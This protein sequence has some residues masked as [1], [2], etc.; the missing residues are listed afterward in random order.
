MNTYASKTVYMAS[1]NFLWIVSSF[2]SRN[3]LLL[4][5][6][7]FHLPLTTQSR[8]WSGSMMV[9]LDLVGYLHFRLDPLMMTLWIC[10]ALKSFLSTSMQ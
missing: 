4:R 3:P 9:I 7:M 6:S 8:I 5:L 2:K 1:K 10:S